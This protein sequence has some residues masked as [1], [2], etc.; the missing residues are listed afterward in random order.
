MWDPYVYVVFGPVSKGLLSVRRA[1][2]K[3]CIC[4]LRVVRAV[5]DFSSRNLGADKK[6]PGL[7]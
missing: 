5:V 4:N 6:P 2:I 1:N 3:S 7:D